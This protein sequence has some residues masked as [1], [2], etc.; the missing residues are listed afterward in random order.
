M[1]CFDAY[2]LYDAQFAKIVYARENKPL[3][4]NW[5]TNFVTNWDKLDLSKRLR[6]SNLIILS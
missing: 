4:D 3:M 6:H 1:I 2:T 5:K